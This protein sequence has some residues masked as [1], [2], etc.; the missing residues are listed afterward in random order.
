MG[1]DIYL[2]N[3]GECKRNKVIVADA[4]PPRPPACPPSAPRTAILSARS[5]RALRAWLDHPLK[6]REHGA[7]QFICPPRLGRVVCLDPD[8]RP[9]SEG[10]AVGS[11]LIMFLGQVG[12]LPGS[13]PCLLGSPSA[14]FV[15][16]ILMKF[17]GQRRNRFLRGAT[18][19]GNVIFLTSAQLG[20]N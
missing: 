10:P 13:S 20:A 6:D 14:C 8:H 7:R 11:E 5:G 12:F 3:L 19:A 1:A 15:E 2:R 4:M 18:T 17:S 9:G 16:K